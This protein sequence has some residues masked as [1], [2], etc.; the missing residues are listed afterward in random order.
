M[1]LEVTTDLDSPQYSSYSSIYI[2]IEFIQ[3][4]QAFCCGAFGSLSWLLAKFACQVTFLV[5]VCN[6]FVLVAKQITS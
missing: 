2:Q 4:A 3:K 6:M 5:S 1:C